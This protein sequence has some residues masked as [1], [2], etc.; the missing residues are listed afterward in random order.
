[1]TKFKFSGDLGLLINKAEHGSPADIDFIM[2]NLTINSSLPMTRYID[3]A[4]GLVNNNLGIN[5]IE[6]YLFNGTQIQRNYSSLFFNRK[7]DWEIV[8]KAYNMGLI[9]EIQAFAR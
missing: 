4:L 6:F 2:A 9:D 8:K 7:G 3:F 1:M 5:R